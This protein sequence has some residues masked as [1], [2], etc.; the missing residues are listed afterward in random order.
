[1]VC[2]YITSFGR[3]FRV[4]RRAFSEEEGWG[5]GE[6]RV[7]A[8][9][10]VGGGGEAHIGGEAE[11]GAETQEGVVVFLHETGTVA[12]RRAERS[13]LLVVLLLPVVLLLLQWW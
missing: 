5:E 2:Y 12:L 11:L 7:G 4:A 1:M 13:K 9:L 10:V 6:G 8:M 3:G